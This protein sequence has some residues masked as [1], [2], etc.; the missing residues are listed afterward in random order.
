MILHKPIIKNNLNSIIVSS[1]IEIESTKEI[2]NL[3]YEI[4][5]SLEISEM[6]D[7]FVVAIIFLAMKLKEDIYINSKI[8]QKLLYGLKR[9]QGYFKFWFPELKEILIKNSVCYKK[10]YISKR[11]AVAFSSGVDSLYTVYSHLPINESMQEYQINDCLFVHGFDFSLNHKGYDIAKKHYEEFCE[12]LCLKLIGVKTNFKIIMDKYNSW[13]ISHGLGLASIAL[14]INNFYR[15]YIGSSFPYSN[16]KPW[17]SNPFTDSFASTEALDIIH[18]GADK[19]RFNKIKVISSWPK[20][21]DYL[22]VCWEHPDGI[23]NCGYCEKCIRTMIAL[24]ILNKL[25][26]YTTFSENLTLDKVKNCKLKKHHAEELIKYA[27]IY[28]RNDIADAIT[29]K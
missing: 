28:K 6:S 1:L 12:S 20:S 23:K 25:D 10:E 24:E 14:L 19:D 2:I 11:N 4:P 5:D 17:G 18:Y 29:Y 7:A 3:W 27:K 15:F 21:Y 26:S 8:S 22:R 13:E 16:L 9:I